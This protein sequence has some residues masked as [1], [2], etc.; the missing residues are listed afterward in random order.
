TPDDD[1]GL[2]ALPGAFGTATVV[3]GIGGL[4]LELDI[5]P[6]LAP[7]ELT[8]SLPTEE[9]VLRSDLWE[10][11]GRP[12]THVHELGPIPAPSFLRVAWSSGGIEAFRSTWPINIADPA[13]LPAPQD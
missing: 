6:S 3:S 9:I 5:D 12:T 7:A 4:R 8:V 13:L 11:A 2:R 10:E 1:D